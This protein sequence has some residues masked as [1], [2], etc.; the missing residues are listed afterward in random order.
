LEKVGTIGCGQGS[1]AL[2]VILSLAKAGRA[3]AG[4][5]NDPRRA[6]VALTRA[7]IATIVV[8]SRA[9]LDDYSPIWSDYV[10]SLPPEEVMNAHAQRSL[11]CGRSKRTLP[12]KTRALMCMAVLAGQTAVSQAFVAKNPGYDPPVPYKKVETGMNMY[13]YIA[14]LLAL[15]AILV[16]L[17]R[18]VA[19]KVKV[20]RKKR[21]AQRHQDPETDPGFTWDGTGSEGTSTGTYAS[22]SPPPPPPPPKKKLVRHKR[23]K[24]HPRYPRHFHKSSSARTDREDRLTPAGTRGRSTR[25]APSTGKSRPRL[26]RLPVPLIPSLLLAMALMQSLTPVSSAT[27]GRKMTTTGTPSQSVDLRNGSTVLTETSLNY[28]ISSTSVEWWDLH[29]WTPKCDSDAMKAL[30]LYTLVSLAFTVVLTIALGLCCVKKICSSLRN[31]RVRTAS[32]IPGDPR[33][34]W[35]QMS[36]PGREIRLPDAGRRLPGVV[37]GRVIF[38]LVTLTTLVGSAAAMPGINSHQLTPDQGPQGTNLPTV[39]GP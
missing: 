9:Y 13:V 33:P 5:L 10:S 34:A 38:A 11:A 3:G 23:S 27:L 8:G 20:W 30:V 18:Y 17:S 21:K 39:Y 4:L 28:S 25:D 1:Q 35:P 29:D 12:Q 24:T 26:P 6:N 7:K 16:T 22:A 19:R 14:G 15:G 37:N 32:P 2:I 36:L 31:R